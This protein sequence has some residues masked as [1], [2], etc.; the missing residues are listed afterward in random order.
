MRSLCFCLIP[1]SF[2]CAVDTFEPIPDEFEATI[3]GGTVCTPSKAISGDNDNPDSEADLSIPITYDICLYDCLK[4]ES[5]SFRW[6]WQCAGGQC[7]IVPLVTANVVK[8]ENAEGCDGR[9]IEDPPADQCRNESFSFSYSPPQ[10]KEGE[11]QHGDFTMVIPYLTIESAQRV[12]EAMDDGAGT[13]EAIEP[14]IG[15]QYY[16][17]RQWLVNFSPDNP[18]V[19]EDDLTEMDCHSLPAP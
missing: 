16:P 7:S 13:R 8:V 18:V 5:T 10:S 19:A 1:L 15:Q 3:V 11:Y 14:E 4:I 12:K 9:L 2:S 6:Y 17:E